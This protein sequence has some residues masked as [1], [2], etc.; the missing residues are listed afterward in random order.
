M[1][2]SARRAADGLGAAVDRLE[3]GM[4]HA[5][6]SRCL[7]RRGLSRMPRPA[8]EEVRRFEWP[9]PGD[10][11]QMDTKRFARFHGPGTRSPATGDRT[12]A[13]KRAAR[14]AGSSVTRS[15]TTTAAWPTPRSTD[16]KAATVT[17]FIARALAFFA[18]HGITAQRLQ[19]D[20]AWTYTHNRSLRELLAG[21]AS[22]T[23]GSRRAPRSATA[24][25]SAT[26]RPSS[27]NGPR[28]ALPNSA[29]R[30]AAL[31]LAQPLQQ[32]PKPQLPRKPAAHHPR[33]ERPEAQHL[34][35]RVRRR[36]HRVR[37]MSRRVLGR[38]CWVGVGVGVAPRRRLV[39]GRWLGAARDV[40]EEFGEGDL[41]GTARDVGVIPGRRI[42]GAH[43]VLLRAASR[44]LSERTLAVAF[45]VHVAQGV[46][47]LRR[48]VHRAPG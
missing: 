26:S 38:G 18:D 46:F 13:E 22:S 8:R 47:R 31:T 30:A 41:V 32:H 1:T 43:R 9:C 10:L 4:A 45:V 42:G 34:V 5:T 23:A 2:G 29:P 33:S 40:V 16:E 3:L 48:G 27:A 7:M 20:N 37:R 44:E 15:S 21:T 24:R 36:H 39:V 35:R 25:S 6:V 12:G 14:S 19:T 28:T 11:L 17:A